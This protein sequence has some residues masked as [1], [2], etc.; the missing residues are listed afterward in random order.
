MGRKEGEKGAIALSFGRAT[1]G[2]TNTPLYYSEDSLRRL[3]FGRFDIRAIASR[4][5]RRIVLYTP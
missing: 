2:R 1:F 5:H 3:E 4:L